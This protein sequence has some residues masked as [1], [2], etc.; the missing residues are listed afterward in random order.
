[1]E[2]IPG[3][4]R[5]VAQQDSVSGSPIAAVYHSKLTNAFYIQVLKDKGYEFESMLIGPIPSHAFEA[6]C[7]VLA[8]VGSM[9]RK[10]YYLD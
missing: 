8:D 1:M 10:F 7:N 2:M 4:F 6:L 9:D 3:D 5:K